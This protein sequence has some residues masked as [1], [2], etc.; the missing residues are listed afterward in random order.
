MLILCDVSGSVAECV[1]VICG[2]AQ[3]NYHP[4]RMDLLHVLHRR[5]RH[6]H[7]LNPEPR[8]QWDTTDSRI[9]EYSRGC[10]TVTEVRNLR[11]LSTWA[12]TLI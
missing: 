12:D 10:D 3:A 6:I 4:P 9:G 2:D 5:V 11:Q 7:W 8:S 1:L